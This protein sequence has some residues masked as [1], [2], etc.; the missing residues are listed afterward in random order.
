MRI[1]RTAAVGLLLVAGCAADGPE[2]RP[3]VFAAA[4]LRT[5][6][7][8]VEPLCRANGHSGFR[9]SYAGSSALARQLIDGA[10]ADVF[11]SADLDWMDEVARAGLIQAS[12]RVNLLGNRLVLVAPASR[13]PAALQIAPGFPIA[14]ALGDG[15][16]AVADPDAVPAGKYAKAALMTLGVWTDV[17][18]R[19]APAE[20]VR[21]ALLLVSRAETPLG[22]VYQTDAAAD[23]GVVIVDEFDPATHPPIVYPAALTSMAGAAAAG[24][25][26][27]LRADAARAVFERWGF[28]TIGATEPR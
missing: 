11:I 12:T 2:S 23:S 19:L 25:L 28:T 8:E 15:R 1:S 13:A 3:L 6:L 22:I 7:D 10:P 5:A 9:A 14:A 4:S 26:R 17:E 21:A 16:L 18:G 27:C 24:V 20:N